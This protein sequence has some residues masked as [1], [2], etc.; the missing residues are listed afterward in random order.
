MKAEEA[1]IGPSSYT[2][3][4]SLHANT[5]I[6]G[7]MRNLKIVSTLA[8]V[9]LASMLGWQIGAGILGNIELRDDMRDVASQLAL[10]VGLPAPLSDDDFRAAIVSRAKRYDIQLEPDQVTVQR[11]GPGPYATVYLRADYTVPIRIPGCAFQLH[12]TPESGKRLED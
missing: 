11:S 4:F 6:E 12:F 2:A 8:I 7:G 10:H 1:V 3:L 5:L 9:A